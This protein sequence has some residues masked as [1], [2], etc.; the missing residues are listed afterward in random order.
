MSANKQTWSPLELAEVAGWG[1]LEA[2]RPADAMVAFAMATTLDPTR[3]DLWR[4]YGT[5]LAQRTYHAQALKAFARALEID[6]RDL[7]STTHAAEIHLEMLEY[8]RAIALLQRALELD[9][10]ASHPHGV[11]ARVLIRKTQRLLEQRIGSRTAS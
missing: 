9:P 5:A 1:A 7:E 10:Q 11:R 3:A 6:P 2:A 8:H 4:G